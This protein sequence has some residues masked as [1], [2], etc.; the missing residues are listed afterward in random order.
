MS[1]WVIGD[2][3]GCSEELA[4]LLAC[5]DAQGPSDVVWVGDLYTKGPD[6]AGVWALL[7]DRGGRAVRGNHD[8]RLQRRIAGHRTKDDHAAEV[9]RRLDAEDL[10]WRE[11]LASLPL[12]LDVAGWTVVHASVD[13]SGEL[14]RT[15]ER[16]FLARRRYPEDRAPH[17]FWWSVYKG[18]RRVVFGH[19]AVRGL[20]QVHHQGHL[21]IA[22]LDTGCV[23]GGRLT[24]M[25]LEDGFLLQVPAARVHMP[26]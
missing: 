11:H 14:E 22:G 13:P 15:T 5:I 1:T 9:I 8:V 21:L 12:H 25:R 10:S 20:I 4:A 26:V 3:H 23:Y 2:V 18:T 24:A 16:D 17:P 19:D 7:R 6:P